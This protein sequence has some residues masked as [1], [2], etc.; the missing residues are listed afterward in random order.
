MKPR[1]KKSKAVK[2]NG[3]FRSG[4]EAKLVPPLLARGAEYEPVFLNYTSLIGKRYIPDVVLPNGIALEIKGWFTPA[5]RSKM[6]AVKQCYPLLD[7]RMVLASPHQ[8]LNKTSKTTQAMWC[9]KHD[10]K[11]SHDVPLVWEL[12]PY[13]EASALIL[14][15]AQRIVRKKRSV[16]LPLPIVGEFFHD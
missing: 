8:K 4:M 1:A 2:D 12:E 15:G 7:I 6:I 13:N 10:F 9:D 3:G 5:D 16:Q 14:A 11:W